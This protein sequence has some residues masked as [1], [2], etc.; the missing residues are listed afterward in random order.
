VALLRS[1]RAPVDVPEGTDLGAA[2]R[3]L[4]RDYVDGGRELV[5]VGTRKPIAV[6]D[7]RGRREGDE[8]FLDLPSGGTG[9]FQP[10]VHID[11][12]VTLVGRA[13]DGRFTVLVGD[14]SLADDLLGTRRRTPC[15]RSTTRSPRR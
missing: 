12:F 15:R 3:R 9:A 8:Y 13:D 6:P 14:P 1:P 11:M 7:F 10:I 5:L 2:V 4:F